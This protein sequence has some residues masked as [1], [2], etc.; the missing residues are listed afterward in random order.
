MPRCAGVCGAALQ[1]ELA[2][3]AGSGNF[4]KVLT[5]LP[6]RSYESVAGPKAQSSDGARRT[7]AER[8]RASGRACSA[9]ASLHRHP[10][11][12]RLLPR[13]SRGPYRAGVAGGGLESPLLHLLEQRR[14]VQIEQL[15]RLVLV[16][17]AEFESLHDHVGFDLSQ[18]LRHRESTGRNLRRQG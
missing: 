7:P 10:G 9:R 1:P 14:P 11:G 3:A 18:H 2:V 5:T 4:V 16:V 15:G 13:P 12:G 8:V 17:V 6:A